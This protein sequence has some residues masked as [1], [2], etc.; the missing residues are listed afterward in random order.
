MAGSA[1]ENWTGTQTMALMR[2]DRLGGLL[3]EYERAA[4]D[5]IC[6][7]YTPAECVGKGRWSPARH[8]LGVQSSA[9]STRRAFDSGSSDDT[10]ILRSWTRSVVKGCRLDHRA[11]C[12]RFASW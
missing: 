3:H 11:V 4:W 8:G 9:A 5:Q 6:A 2:R 10:K 1:I 12:F 7:P